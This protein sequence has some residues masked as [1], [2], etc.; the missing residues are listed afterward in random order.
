MR[1]HNSQKEKTK[2]RTT[3]RDLINSTASEYSLVTICVGGG[4]PQLYERINFME[5]HATLLWGVLFG[6]IGSGYLL[7]GRKNRQAIALLSGLLLIVEPYFVTGTFLMV[8]IAVA[9]MALP[10]FVRY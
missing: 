4:V 3:K 9:L 1:G 6:A 8:I 2:R 10:F 7:Y 5:S